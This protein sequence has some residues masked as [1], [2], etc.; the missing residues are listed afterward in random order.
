M[1]NICN[2]IECTGCMACANV[3]AHHAIHIKKDE[4]GFDRPVID[5]SLCV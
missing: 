5:K 4:E 2:I 3:C 1:K